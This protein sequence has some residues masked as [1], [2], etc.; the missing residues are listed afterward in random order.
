MEINN[1]G[2]LAD[3]SWQGIPEFKKLTE[4]QMRCVA[5][6]VDNQ[7]PFRRMALE[8]REERVVKQLL[9]V[10]ELGFLKT[11][12][13]K[14]AFFLYKAMDYDYLLTMIELYEKKLIGLQSILTAMDMSDD[15]AVQKKYE[16]VQKNVAT[17]M[18]QLQ[19]FEKELE[20]RGKIV[21]NLKLLL[22]GIE[23]FQVRAK[24]MKMESS[25][26]KNA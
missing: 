8:D 4:L 22:S 18:K 15:L 1:E 19:E 23:K 13:Y 25:I 17:Y 26:F 7:S 21:K 12:K 16:S 5:Y 11:A 6:I 2:K 20:M 9:G 24:Q 10:E 3:S 14:E